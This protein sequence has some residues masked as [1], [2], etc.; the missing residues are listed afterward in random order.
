M[1]HKLMLF[2]QSGIRMALLT[3]LHVFGVRPEYS[4]YG[5]DS[6]VWFYDS[7]QTTEDVATEMI[8]RLR[9]EFEL[10]SVEVSFGH[11]VVG[12]VG[13]GLMNS[14]VAL[15]KSITALDTAGIAVSFT[16]YGVSPVSCLLGVP[17]S[18][19]KEAVKVLYDAIL[20]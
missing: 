12:L 6:I 1:L 19:A 10:D 16:N 20:S 13:E 8:E 7:S 3:M 2:K 14:A 5:I 18:Q 15:G 17:E 4:V 11:A 9:Q